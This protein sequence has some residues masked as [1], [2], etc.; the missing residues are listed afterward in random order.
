MLENSVPRNIFSTSFFSSF[1]L[2]HAAFTAFSLDH[3]QCDRIGRFFAY[4]V[5][6]YF[7]HFLFK[8]EHKFLKTFFY[9]ISF[10]LILTKNGLGHILGYSFIYCSGRPDHKCSLAEVPLLTDTPLKLS[11]SLYNTPSRAIQ[12]VLQELSLKKASSC[13]QRCR[14]SPFH[15]HSE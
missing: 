14:K 5:I 10:S 8:K 12:T 7:G 1:A 6:V 11:C 15:S 13:K 9:G 3:K 4:W 2:T